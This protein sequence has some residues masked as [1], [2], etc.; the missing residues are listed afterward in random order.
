MPARDY[1]TPQPPRPSFTRSSLEPPTEQPR[2][3]SRRRMRMQAETDLY[4][5]LDFN[6]KHKLIPCSV[7]Y[8]L[9]DRSEPS[10]SSF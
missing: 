10:I 2:I 8:E 5:H 6:P 3:S 7:E 9:E 4:I 1:S